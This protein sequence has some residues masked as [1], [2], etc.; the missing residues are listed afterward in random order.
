M[1]NQ[2]GLINMSFWEKKQNGGKINVAN[3]LE[4]YSRLLCA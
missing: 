2:A 4:K 3:I 1:A